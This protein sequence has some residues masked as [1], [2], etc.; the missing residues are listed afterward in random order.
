MLAILKK[1]RRALSRKNLFCCLA[2]VMTYLSAASADAT[3]MIA[4]NLAQLSENAESAFVIKIESVETTTTSIGQSVDVVSGTV[5]EPVFGDVKTSQ[6]ISWNQFRLGKNVMLPAM[7]VYEPGKEYLI[8]LTGKGPGTGLQAP[9]GLG[10]GMFAITRNPETGKAM[11]RNTY[12]NRSLLVGLN[13]DEVAEDMVEQ[14][15]KQR[16]MP[17]AQKAEVVNKTKAQ[18]RGRTSQSLD[19]LKEAARFLHEKKKAG[20]TPSLD[21]RTTAPAQIIR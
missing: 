2:C 7:P 16:S 14:N 21:Y 1:S 13:V 3:T 5:I 15:P 19:T 12:M 11:A 8:F 20:R 17:A 4:A 6:A 18:L 9:V 10:Q